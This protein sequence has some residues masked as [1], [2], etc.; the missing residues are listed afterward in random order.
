M[1]ALLPAFRAARLDPAA[2]EPLPSA[3]GEPPA[4]RVVVHGRDAHA[5]WAA[6]RDRAEVTGHWPLI[7]GEADEAMRLFET[8][9]D[10]DPTSGA[11]L[12]AAAH[13]APEAW[14]RDRAAELGGAERPIGTWPALATPF[15]D[16]GAH[17]DVLTRRPHPRVAIGLF[18]LAE[19]EERQAGWGPEIVFARLR[20]GGWNDCPPPA[21][22]VAMHR[23]WRERHGAMP[24]AV[25]FDVVEC[26]VPRPPE[27]Q[28]AAMALAEQHYG[29]CPDVVEQGVGTIADLAGGLLGGS[30]WYFWWD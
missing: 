21:V 2:A 17:L 18:R 26:R 15:H 24:V 11:I 28:A 14:L 8:W 27:D 19:G 23:A 5:T 22:H 1:D 9:D 13:T 4:W 6:F 30:T 7:M 29:Y 25:T 3:P 12:A 10:E 16:L 20:Y